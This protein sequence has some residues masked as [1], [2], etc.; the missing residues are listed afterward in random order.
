MAAGSIPFDFWDDWP[1]CL[2]WAMYLHGEDNEGVKEALAMTTDAMT[3]RYIKM[4][5]GRFTAEGEAADLRDELERSKGGDHAQGEAGVAQ[6]GGA[7]TGD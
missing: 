7:A 2:A 1:D 3:L 6:R 4:A 5:V